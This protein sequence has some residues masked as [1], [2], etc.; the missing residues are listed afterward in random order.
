MSFPKNGSDH[1]ICWGAS[2]SQTGAHV[3]IGVTVGWPSCDIGLFDTIFGEGID[4][5]GCETRF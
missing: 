3:E 5:Q 4:G 1:P 2:M